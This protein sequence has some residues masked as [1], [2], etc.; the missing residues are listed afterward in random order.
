MRRSAS[1]G[2]PTLGRH[3]VNAWQS[4]SVS[5]DRWT[6]AFWVRWRCS[7]AAETAQAR[8]SQAA[9]AARAA[10]AGRQPHGLGRAPRRRPVGRGRRRSRRSR[11]ST[12]TSRSCARRCPAGRCRRARPATRSRSTP[13]A[14]DL[15]RFERLRTEGR[16]ALRRGRRRDRRRR[17][18]ARRSR[19][20]AGR[21]SPSSPS[22][23]RASRPPTSRSAHRV[24][25]EDRIDADLAL[26]PPRRRRRRARGARA[27]PPAAR[28]P[29]RPAD[30][31]ALP[32]GPPGRRA[33]GLPRLPR[34]ARRAARPRAL[35][36]APRARGP[37]P[38]P[39][40][41]STSTAAPRLRPAPRD[42]PDPLRAEPRRLLDRLPGRRRRPARHR[43]RARL[44][45]LV[46]GRVGV[47]RA[48]VVLHAAG[49]AR[50]G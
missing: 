33:R 26:G 43:L 38:A 28:A 23:S 36:A 39:G 29:A 20:G 32:L 48:G 31:R 1:G 22:R 50:A 42:G 18:C 15:V 40:R 30:A 8:G 41:R 2:A 9:R 12:S 21:R 45:V 5:R 47:A 24:C 44:G 7:T 37:D 4:D 34:R 11:W 6:T 10:A 13:E 16:A 3:P 27:P 17:A 49:A 19:S 46:P 35:A 25:L 14:I